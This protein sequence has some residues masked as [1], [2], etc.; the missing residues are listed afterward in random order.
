MKSRNQQFDNFD[1]AMRELIKVPHSDIKA[2]LD[3]ERS[4]KTKKREAKKPSASRDS[5][6]REGA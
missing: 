2:K 3:A 4:A 6:D 5:S 1:R